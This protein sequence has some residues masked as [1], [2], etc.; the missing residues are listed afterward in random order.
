MSHASYQLEAFDCDKPQ[1]IITRSI[2]SSCNPEIG[3]ELETNNNGEVLQDYTILQK[4]LTF[5]YSATLCTLR[6]SRQYFN[7]VWKSHARIAA[8]AKIYAQETLR[9][10]ECIKARQTGIYVDHTS[11]LEH[12]LNNKVEVNYFQLV[13]EGSLAYDRKY[14]HC[15]GK[16]AMVDGKRVASLLTTE[17]LEFT[18]REVTVR[19]E[20]ESGDIIIREN[21]V[22]IPAAYRSEG[23]MTTDF[24]TLV[25]HRDRPLCPWKRVRDITASRRP[26]TVIS[27][28]ELVD[29]EQQVHVTLHD[30]IAA[31]EGCPTGYVWLST[32]ESRIVVV[33]RL[34]GG[35]WREGDFPELR[36]EEI[37]LAA[38]INLKLEQAFYQLR[39][40]FQ[41]LAK[42]QKLS[43]SDI[44]ALS[45]TDKLDT[46]LQA[47]YL[48]FA[49]GETL[50]SLCCKKRV[51][52]VAN[53]WDTRACYRE[54]PIWI[55]TKN[56]RRKL[57]F[58]APGSRLLLN[59][60]RPEN[61]TQ[62]KIVPRTYQATSGPGWR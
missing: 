47:Q 39:K 46:S 40:R 54:M 49:R 59:S 9:V 4:V 53:D 6:R 25:F 55:Y 34:C 37:L 29:E 35:A 31:G 56:N 12:P 44:R 22:S 51:A 23:G 58:L 50:Y 7:C 20:Y 45:H 38:G 43:C 33:Q 11:G 41:Q 62:A 26:S 21:G 16:D 10:D 15:S 57:R 2:P 52:Y 18:I 60:L 3:G 13:V 14:V 1:D 27:G 36:P 5:E 48:T 32:G 24:G 61:C 8:P 19:E 42:D 17:S 30:S 28:S